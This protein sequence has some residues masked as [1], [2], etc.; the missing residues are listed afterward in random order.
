MHVLSAVMQRHKNHISNHPVGITFLVIICGAM[1]G[2]SYSTGTL[3]HAVGYLFAVWLGIFIIDAV[4]IAK[5]AGEPVFIIKR[6]VKKE[7][8]LIITCTLLGAIFL[9][10]RFFSD[11]ANLPGMVKL[12]AIPLIVF[13]FPIV[14]GLI[15]LFGY[16]YTFKELGI[17]LRYWYLPILL[18]LVWGGI[19]L[20]VA[21]DK[22]HW[23]EAM[24]EYSILNFL[25]TGLI[26]AALSEEFSRMLMQTRLGA[27]SGNMFTGIF[28]SSMVWSAMHIP[29]GYSQSPAGFSATEAIMSTAFL[30]PLGIFWGYLTHRTQSILPAILMHGFNMWGLQNF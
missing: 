24:K 16:K 23:G 4:V 14:P 27:A 18:H 10:I 11:W 12:A 15:F 13:T 8:L 19:T 2:Y 26:T 1:L 17:N 6:D 30:I 21:Y 29:I 7:L 3:L 9:C 20:L 5:P 25:F 28:V 22:S